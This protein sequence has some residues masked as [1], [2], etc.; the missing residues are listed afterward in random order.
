MWH[1]VIEYHIIWHGERSSDSGDHSLVIILVIIKCDH[2]SC[3]CRHARKPACEI[4]TKIAARIN[5]NQVYKVCEPCLCV[6]HSSKLTDVQHVPSG[7][8]WLSIPMPCRHRP[9]SSQGRTHNKMHLPK[10]FPP[11][12]HPSVEEPFGKQ[13]DAAQMSSL[14]AHKPKAQL[15]YVNHFMSILWCAKSRIVAIKKV[16]RWESQITVCANAEDS[17][18]VCAPLESWEFKNARRLK[19]RIE[20]DARRIGTTSPLLPWGSSAL[21]PINMDAVGELS[22]QSMTR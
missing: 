6:L 2:G 9:C 11:L 14:P 21:V 15:S 5:W 13:L 19:A 3:S 12:G 8:C 18:A 1:G 22:T 17:A 7:I 4:C 16:A 10:P 20:D